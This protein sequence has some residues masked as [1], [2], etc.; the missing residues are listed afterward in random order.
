MLISTAARMLASPVRM[1]TLTNIHLP[2]HFLSAFSPVKNARTG[3][4]WLIPEETSIKYPGKRGSVN[5][6]NDQT[7]QS[8]KRASED[9][10]CALAVGEQSKSLTTGSSTQSSNMTAASCQQHLQSASSEATVGSLPSPSLSLY[11]VSSF[12][13]LEKVS[14]LGSRQ[15][16]R[17]LPFFWKDQLGLQ[18]R[19]IVWRKDMPDYVLDQMRGE[20]MKGLSYLASRLGNVYLVPMQGVWSSVDK[21]SQAGAFLWTGVK[22]RETAFD[23]TTQES[24]GSELLP[25][26][27]YAMLDWRKHRT[28]VYNLPYVLG[29]RHFGRLMESLPIFENELIAMKR[30]SNTAGLQMIFWKIMGY[31]A[32]RD[33]LHRPEQDQIKPGH[34]NEAWNQA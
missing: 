33:K 18:S 9:S 3:N 34:T 23:E 30:K 16:H 4:P 5:S 17:F 21:V 11:V 14:L 13:A 15:T 20:A 12:P 8:S 31:L 26:P 10:S 32:S 19:N 24:G 7:F 25:P 1:C 27:P 22:K 2:L 6:Q 28:V 29:D